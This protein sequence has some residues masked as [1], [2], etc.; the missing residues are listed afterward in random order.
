LL[1]G[2]YLKALRHFTISGTS[3]CYHR[4]VLTDTSPEAREIQLSVY[5][6]MSGAQRV[7]LAFE[8]SGF[9]RDL[10]RA[11][12]RQSHPEWDASQVTRE[13]LRLA[14]FPQP[15]PAHFK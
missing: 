2:E 15:L 5:R 8:M 7:L 11:R 4:L 1:A 12:V 3:P 9:A 14:F 6:K 10:S 13:I